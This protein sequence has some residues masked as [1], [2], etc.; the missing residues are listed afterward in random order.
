M[1]DTIAVFLALRRLTDPPL[2]AYL[3]ACPSP[4]ARYTYCLLSSSS[5]S[6]PPSACTLY[7]TAPLAKPT[8]RPNLWHRMTECDNDQSPLARDGVLL[9]AGAFA[10]SSGSLALFLAL[11]GIVL[12]T[13]ATLWSRS[14]PARSTLLPPSPYS[15]AA[16]AAAR[17]GDGRAQLWAVA[18]AETG[19]GGGGE[20]GGGVRGVEGKGNEL[21]Q[22]FSAGRWRNVAVALACVPWALDAA[23][24]YC[25]LRL[26]ARCVISHSRCCC[27]C[28]QLF[29]EAGSD[30]LIRR[31]R[32]M[33]DTTGYSALR[34]I[35]RSLCLCFRFKFVHVSVFCSVV[36]QASL[37][38]VWGAL[39]VFFI[40]FHCHCCRTGSTW[41]AVGLIV[42]S[43]VYA[44]CVGALV[45]A[46]G[47][48][49][50]RRGEVKLR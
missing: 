17:P 48:K 31:A 4:T 2:P 21:A 25:F 44:F 3:P 46:P 45:M 26:A 24:Q 12:S 5:S 29:A 34:A 38:K 49:V 37:A 33:Q 43:I 40:S 30:R 6:S 15:R 28:L 19:G 39:V 22:R 18:A 32:W 14:A 50:I 27:C 7:H 42:A 35:E 36:M 11:W 9:A 41:L 8:K 20:D 23:S 16:A 1:Y 10:V 13:G 47:A